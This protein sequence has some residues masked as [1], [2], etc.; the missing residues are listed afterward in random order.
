MHRLI[1]G[2]ANWSRTIVS[3]RSPNPHQKRKGAGPGEP[4]VTRIESLPEDEFKIRLAYG[5][6]RQHQASF[7]VK[8]R[9]TQAGYIAAAAGLPKGCPAE[10]T[11][12]SYLN[13]QVVGT[14]TV[15]LDI[16]HGLLADELYKAEIDQLRAKGR[17]VAEFTKLAVDT[18]RASKQ[19]LASLFHI[20]YI[21]LR[22]IWR[23]TDMVIEV[24]PD[25]V[26]FYK[27]M[28]GFSELGP[29]RHCPRVNAP[30]VLL[31]LD[32]DVGDGWVE[33]YGGRP[34]LAKQV[35]TLYPYFFSPAKDREIA[36]GLLAS[37]RA[38]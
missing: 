1:R 7:L 20:A 18:K 34:E 37:E 21:H 4:T 27:R 25:H 19:V 24:N 8:K 9:Y 26:E 6:D 30:A 22:R 31:W 17:K 29:Q 35:K 15:G 2:G 10:I 16:G 14:L 12:L 36:Q 11:L 23:Y 13:E 32:A 5:E 33:A 38:S 3:F 28:L